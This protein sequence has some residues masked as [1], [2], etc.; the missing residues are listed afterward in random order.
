MTR[1]NHKYIPAL[2]S[3]DAPKAVEIWP[4]LL[5]KA[6]AKYYSTYQSLVGGNTIELME[7]LTGTSAHSLFQ[8]VS[9]NGDG[10][11]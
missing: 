3:I 1:E 7:Q 6:L 9:L 11:L 4:F 2:I 5:L 10:K 8:E